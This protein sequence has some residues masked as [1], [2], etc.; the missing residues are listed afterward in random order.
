MLQLTQG[1]T[2]GNCRERLQVVWDYVFWGILCICHNR[3]VL[4]IHRNHVKIQSLDR[5]CHIYFDMIMNNAAS[6]VG[7]L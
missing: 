7:T 2:E 1:T 6:C 5:Y 4:L 3:K